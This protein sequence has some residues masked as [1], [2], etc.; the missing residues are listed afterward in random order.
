MKQQLK[1]LN[2]L[3]LLF[4]FNFV[5]S[6]TRDSIKISNNLTI[7]ES[8]RIT[9]DD[10]SFVD[11]KSGE[12]NY[13][14]N[15]KVGEWKYY[16]TDKN[17][18]QKGFYKSDIKEGQWKTYF[19]NTKLREVVNYLNGKRDGEQLTYESSCRLPLFSTS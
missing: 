7:Y 5:I 2:L 15:L 8:D 10:S 11:R 13:F 17:L 3:F 16:Y 12:G 9:I 1:T 6:Q 18:W 4:S 19:R 14:Q